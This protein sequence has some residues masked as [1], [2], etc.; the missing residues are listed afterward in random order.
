MYSINMWMSI[1][2]WLFYLDIVCTVHAMCVQLTE[3]L[4]VIDRLQPLYSS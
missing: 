1:E 2:I 3:I 4:L